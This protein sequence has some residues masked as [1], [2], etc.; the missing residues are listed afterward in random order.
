[1]DPLL[2]RLPVLI[3]DDWHDIN[4]TLLQQTYRDFE[5]S[6]VNI[7]AAAEAI[8]AA[9]VGSKNERGVREGR[10]QHAELF[11]EYWNIAFHSHRLK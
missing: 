11:S 10:F 7:S 6:Q 9:A 8:E 5:R 4:L 3:L 1:M 2:R